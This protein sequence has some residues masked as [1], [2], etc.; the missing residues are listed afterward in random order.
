MSG[1]DMGAAISSNARKMHLLVSSGLAK[2]MKW[3]EFGHWMYNQRQ[4][5]VKT[6]I[7]D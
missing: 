4:R 2:S 1:W 5:Q 3:S 6:E 7:L